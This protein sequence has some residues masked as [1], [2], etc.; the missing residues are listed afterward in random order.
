M[1]DGSPPIDPRPVHDGVRRL[2]AAFVEAQCATTK[3]ARRGLPRPL[4]STSST[5]SQNRGAACLPQVLSA[6]SALRPPR[7][8][9]QIFRLAPTNLAP[10]CQVPPS[11]PIP[12]IRFCDWTATRSPANFVYGH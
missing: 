4:P 5:R 8:L 3:R 10:P 2:T 7:P 1:F 9:R 12:H 6:N 11:F